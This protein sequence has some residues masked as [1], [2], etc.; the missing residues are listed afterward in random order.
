MVLPST[1]K[2]EGLQM[3]R[4]SAYIPVALLLGTL[5]VSA[6]GCG[7]IVLGPNLGLLMYPI[8][9]T[10]Y[11][12][13]REEDAFWNH[14]RYER[15]PVL[16]PI[17]PGT[18]CVALDPPTDDEVMRALEKARPVQGGTPFA[19]EIQRNN[20]RIIVEP[21]ADYVDPPRV[22]PLVGPA[23]LHHAQ[24]KCIVYFSEV[25]RVGWPVPHTTTSEECQEVLYIDHDHLHMVGNVDPGPGTGYPSPPPK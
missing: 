6:T 19:H 25:T 7:H 13:K 5:L 20:V 21:I 14:K 11:L 1:G 16:G 3:T 10:P 23:Q 2:A 4:K 15:A 17:Q 9:M 22:Y 8:P 24:Y 12:Q 18:V